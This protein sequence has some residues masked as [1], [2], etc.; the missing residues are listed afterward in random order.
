MIPTQ[1]PNT[2]IVKT[3]VIYGSAKDK[4][5]MTPART[6]LDEQVLTYEEHVISAS[7]TMRR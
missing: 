6:Y 1:P 2:R 3:I 7:I 4:E 5:F